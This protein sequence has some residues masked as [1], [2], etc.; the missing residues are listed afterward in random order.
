MAT[1]KQKRLVKDAALLKLYLLLVPGS[2]VI[3]ASM[4]YDSSL[5]NGLQG[6]DHWMEYE[7]CSRFTILQMGRISS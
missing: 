7:L 4:G 6:V 5:M 3:S 1:T 2:L